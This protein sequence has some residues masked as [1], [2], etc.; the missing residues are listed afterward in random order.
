MRSQMLLVS[1]ALLALVACGGEEDGAGG[2]AGSA[3]AAGQAGGAGGAGQ[4]LSPEMVQLP[5]GFWI[6]S[7]E[8]TRA[9]YQSWLD[10][11]PLKAGQPSECNWNDDYTPGCHWPPGDEPDH[12]VSC[13]DWC[14][15]YAFCSAVG[16]RLCGKIGGGPAALED[17]DDSSRSQWYY[18]CSSNGLYEYPYGNDFNDSAC[19]VEEAQQGGIAGT[20]SFEECKSSE[21]GFEGVFDLTG[22]VREW[23]DACTGAAGADDSCEE[24]GGS[25][26]MAGIGT[27]CRL[28]T[29]AKRNE[30]AEGLGFRCCRDY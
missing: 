30:P 23:T 19:N 4:I 9:Q 27:R 29:T 21:P 24:R 13:V 3:G 14:D 26:G 28:A 17:R 6:D 11:T 12:P 1:A 16:K 8:V 22:N 25:Y 2:G 10:T 15:A 7:T 5:A 20:A 18:A